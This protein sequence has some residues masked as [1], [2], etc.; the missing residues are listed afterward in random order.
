MQDREWRLF[1]DDMVGFCEN[2]IAY[3][4]G[5]DEGTF[6]ENKIA[7]DATMWNLRLIGE[8]ATNVPEHV[9]D[10]HSHIEWTDIIGLRHRLTHAYRIIKDDIIW[11]T[12]QTDIP[13]LLT[14][15]H[16]LRDQ[17]ENQHN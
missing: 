8:A 9:R 5:L 6:I 7:Y 11:K 16:N 10:S 17:I 14:D 1:I 12:I 2:V 4:E 13:K 3:T 15:L